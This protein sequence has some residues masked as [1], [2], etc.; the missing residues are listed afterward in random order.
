MS[1]KPNREHLEVEIKL[2]AP[3]HAQLPDEWPAGLQ[4]RQPGSAQLSAQYFDTP[5][6]ELAQ[7]GYAVRLRLGGA[8]AGW[9][10]KQR[11]RENQQNEWMWHAQD[12]LP[13]EAAEII[14]RIAADASSRLQIVAEIKTQRKTVTLARNSTELYEVADD[15]VTSWDAATGIKRAWRE[16]EIEAL[17][18]DTTDMAEITTA[19][20]A[21]GGMKSLADSKIARAVGALLVKAIAR[22]ASPQT[23]AALGVLDAAD[24]MA[25]SLDS[26]STAN[27]AAVRE[28]CQRIQDIPE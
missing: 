23:I 4:A 5:G 10:I 9:H 20:Y 6:R 19:L 21:C 26:D 3:Q 13:T 14:D 1:V 11:V 8:D 17:T 28:I 12:T 18:P 2:E 24:R 22:G 15:T 16:W 7:A 27:I 25:A